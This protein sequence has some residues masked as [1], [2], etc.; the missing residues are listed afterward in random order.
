MKIKYVVLL[1]IISHSNEELSYVRLFDT[2]VPIMN[3]VKNN[4]W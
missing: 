4:V 1:V 2:P 3:N